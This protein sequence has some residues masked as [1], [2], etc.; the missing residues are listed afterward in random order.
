[1]YDSLSPCSLL[2]V[3]IAGVLAFLQAYINGQCK[4]SSNIFKD[5][6]ILIL[7]NQNKIWLMNKKP[8]VLC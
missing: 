8:R 1:M 7:Q 5:R 3:V 2:K 4:K 6:K